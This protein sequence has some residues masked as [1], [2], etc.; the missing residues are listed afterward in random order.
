MDED[1]NLEWKMR[2]VEENIVI[3][4]DVILKCLILSYS[5][6]FSNKKPFLYIKE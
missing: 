3:R 1:E 5:K 4:I 2:K 6:Q